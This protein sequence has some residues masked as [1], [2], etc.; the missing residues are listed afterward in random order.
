MPQSTAGCLDQHTNTAPHETISTNLENH[1]II[2]NATPIGEK[3][4][5]LKVTFIHEN[6][7]LQRISINTSTAVLILADEVKVCF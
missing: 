5:F 6:L 3:Q 7:L 2:K 4:G 1:I